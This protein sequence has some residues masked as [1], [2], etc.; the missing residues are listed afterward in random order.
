MHFVFP[1]KKERHIQL[2]YIQNKGNFKHNSEALES[3]K[4]KLIPSKHPQPKLQGQKF[5]HCPYCHEK[6]YVA[7]LQKLQIET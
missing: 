2:D 3:Q 7:I 4:G 6:G 1:K 5:A